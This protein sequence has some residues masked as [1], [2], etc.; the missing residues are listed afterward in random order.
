MVVREVLQQLIGL[1]NYRILFS[2]VYCIDRW[3]HL[4]LVTLLILG[5]IFRSTNHSTRNETPLFAPLR[6]GLVVM[7]YKLPHLTRAG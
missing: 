4:H 3:Y 5:S 2:V 1:E 7:V 6:P